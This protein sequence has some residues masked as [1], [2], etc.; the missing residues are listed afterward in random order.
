M[1]YELV[2]AA[3]INHIIAQ[4][5][6]PYLDT[7]RFSRVSERKWVRNRVEGVRD[8]VV[9]QA[10]GRSSYSPIIGFSLDYVP[11]IAGESARW[12]R[13]DKSALFDLR[14]DPLDYE[15][16]NTPAFRKW[17]IA[18]IYGSRIAKEDF[19]RVGQLTAS[20]ATKALDGIVTSHDLCS[21]FEQQIR[22]SPVRFGFYNYTQ[23]PL[24]Y[25]FTL[26]RVGSTEKARKVFSEWKAA[27]KESSIA[28]REVEVLFVRDL[29]QL[30]GNRPDA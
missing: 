26:L 23:Q 22:G 13:T 4:S 2:G 6:V 16:P 28:M 14:F 11:H 27:V 29:N 21:A 30:S 8:L 19:Q 20:H 10:L 17:T 3:E 9:I 1:R 24:A 25:A 7:L 5:F 18:G 12:H 15:M